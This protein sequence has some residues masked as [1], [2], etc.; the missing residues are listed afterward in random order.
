MMFTHHCTACDRNQ[1]IFASMFT[2]VSTDVH[3]NTAIDF[4]CWCGAEQTHATE[5]RSVATAA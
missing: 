2:G 4:T 3:G 5:G 1:L